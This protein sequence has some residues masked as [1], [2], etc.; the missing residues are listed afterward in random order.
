MQMRAFTRATQRADGIAPRTAGAARNKKSIRSQL[1]A[2]HSVQQPLNKGAEDCMP[3]LSL[4]LLIGA[5]RLRLTVPYPRQINRRS[6]H[7][8]RESR[9]LFPQAR[10][11]KSSP[12]R[13]RRPA[14]R[15]APTAGESRET[16]RIIVVHI[17]G[18]AARCPSS[19]NRYKSDSRLSANNLYGVGSVR[20]VTRGM[21]VPSPFAP[22]IDSRPR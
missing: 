9:S 19:A 12:D 18:A 14:E 3:K 5:T 11:S 22:P 6:I 7:R 13:E 10:I 17:R 20:N 15:N 2:L 8:D 4:Q 16:P 1:A 21:P